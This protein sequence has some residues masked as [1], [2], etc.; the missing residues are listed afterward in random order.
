[1]MESA[2][3]TP[4]KFDGHALDRFFDQASDA[5]VNGCAISRSDVAKQE[6]N[7]SN[8]CGSDC[9]GGMGPVLVST[10]QYLPTDANQL[11]GQRHDGNAAMPPRLDVGK[12]CSE[13]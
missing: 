13:V 5:P 6:R 3:I 11:V 8:L 10:R 1:M 9:A 2:R 12:P 7:L 4:Q